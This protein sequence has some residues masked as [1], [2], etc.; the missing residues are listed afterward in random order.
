[1]NSDGEALELEQREQLVVQALPGDLVE[2]AERLV[3]QEH[4]GARA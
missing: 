4:V 1:M 3:E 2:R